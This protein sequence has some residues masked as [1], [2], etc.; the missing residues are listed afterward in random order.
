M[1][2]ARGL[3]WRR[4]QLLAP[5]RKS[6]AGDSRA[7]GVSHARAHAHLSPPPPVSP[8]VGGQRHNLP[9]RRRPAPEPASGHR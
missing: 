7:P 4:P 1:G 9:G 6:A 5:A 2:F 8:A 3:T